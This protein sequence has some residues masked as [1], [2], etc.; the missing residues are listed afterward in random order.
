MRPRH[1][2]GSGKGA[3]SER[4]PDPAFST[5][6]IAEELPVDRIVAGMPKAI[7]AAKGG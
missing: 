7:A 4:R 2:R 5:G 1:L 3:G 6:V